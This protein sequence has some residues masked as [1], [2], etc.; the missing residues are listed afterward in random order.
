[1]NTFV[2]MLENLETLKTEKQQLEDQGM[3]LFDCWIAE[4]K[5]GGTARTKKAHYQ[6]RSRQP[7]F[8]G[9]KSKYLKVDEVGEYQAA[10]ARGK[11]IRQLEKQIAAL[12]RR[13][14]RIEAIALEA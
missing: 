6:L 1:M 13:V 14:E 12:Q 11:A 8:A 10:I 5:P 9:K 4:S 2:A 7:L 3:V